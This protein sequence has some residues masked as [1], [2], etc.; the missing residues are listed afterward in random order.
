MEDFVKRLDKITKEMQDLYQDVRGE[1]SQL[2]ERS[3]RLFQDYFYAGPK[4]VIH[5]SIGTIIDDSF[6]D[7][8]L[9]SRAC[10]LLGEWPAKIC[11]K[12]S[13]SFFHSTPIKIKLRDHPKTEKYFE[14]LGHIRSIFIKNGCNELNMN[15]SEL[16]YNQMLHI[17]ALPHV[18]DA[19]K[20]IWNAF[21]RQN[22]KEYIFAHELLTEAVI[23][24][25]LVHV[26][27]EPSLIKSADKQ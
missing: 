8:N 22:D 13:V 19:I 18:E 21:N 2:I 23:D 26:G 7:E 24:S 27:M 9:T 16:N 4:E 6:S 5:G 11:N 14:V 15:I 1:Y 25:F 20:M 3:M 10:C 12:K 17:E